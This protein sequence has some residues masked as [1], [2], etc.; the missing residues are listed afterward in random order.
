MSKF[1]D[2]YKVLGVERNVSQSDLQKAYRKL[3]RKYHPDINQEPGAEDKFKE[4]GEA[5]EVLKDPEK[6][7]AYDA[8]GANWKHGQDFRPPPGWGGAGG[9][10]GGNPF[11]G[12]GA[13]GFSDF[14]NMFFEQ[15]QQQSG[16]G[17]QGFGGMGGMGG[18][19]PFGGA[20]FGARPQ[21]GQDLELDVN[22]TLDEVFKGVKKELNV[23]FREPKGNGSMRTRSKTINIKV[24]PGVTEGKVLKLRGQG[25][26]GLHGGPNGDLSLKIRV[27]KHPTFELDGVHLRVKVP[28]APWV[29]ALGGTVDVPTMDGEVTMKVPPGVQ[30]GQKLRLKGKGLPQKSG[31]DGN[32][33]AELTIEIPKDLT[34]EQKEAFE[35]LA[36]LF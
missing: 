20:G 23:E 28:L 12:G 2:Y 29:A 19:N 31:D 7:R 1:Q 4:V 5:Y 22:V 9:M 6:R 27:A 8:L 36:E 15:A 18:G 24:P 13:G 17:G 30:G 11:A 14:F 34:V 33:Y 32:L 26:K 25:A 21:K 35:K 16:V 3:A 10:G